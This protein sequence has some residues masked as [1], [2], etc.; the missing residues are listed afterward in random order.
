MLSVYKYRIYFVVFGH[1][2]DGSKAALRFCLLFIF[3]A[4]IAMGGY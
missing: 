4:L 3:L 2:Q 1:V